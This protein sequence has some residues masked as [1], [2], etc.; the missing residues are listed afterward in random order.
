MKIAILLAGHTN[1]AMAPKFNDY[2]D[3]FLALFNRSP[4]FGYFE[5]TTLPVV[6]NVF[7]G[8]IND[9]DGYLITGSAYGVYDNAP[10]IPKLMTLIKQVYAAGKPLVGICFGHQIIAQSLGG[11]AQKWDHGWGLGI[12]DIELA[13]LPEWIDEDIT[14]ASLIHVHQD[15]VI[16]LPPGGSSFA[17]SPFCKIAGYVI[18]D[19]VF[20]LQ[21]HPEFDAEYTGALVDLIKNRAGS[22][23][24]AKA[25]L[26]LARP[27]DG[28]KFGH[29]ILRFFAKHKSVSAET[30]LR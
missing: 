6:D 25:K 2:N 20:T 10:F 11:E 26:S 3:L 7:P 19:K 18:D 13:D 17:S 22:T 15:Q 8:Q 4:L 28:I 9:F 24:A 27:H 29:W 16:K 12:S 5:F 23:V 21:G 30:A 14:R 1:N